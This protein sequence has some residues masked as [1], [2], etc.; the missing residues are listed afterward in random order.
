MLNIVSKMVNEFINRRLLFIFIILSGI[1]LLMLTNFCVSN[2]DSNI[3][4]QEIDDSNAPQPK[5]KP[6]I[7]WFHNVPMTKAVILEKA[8]SNGIISHVLLLYQHRLDAPFT[9]VMLDRTMQ[10]AAVCKKYGTKIIWVRT[11]WPTHNVESFRY[12]DFFDPNYYASAIKEVQLE[13]RAIGA[14]FTGIDIEPYG[15]FPF[16]KQLLQGGVGSGKEFKSL[17]SAVKEAVSMSGQVDFVMPTYTAS[18]RHLYNVVVE[19]GKWKIAEHTY[20]DNPKKINDRRRPFNIFG[21]Y[22]STT[23]RNRRNPKTPFFTAR[24]ILER[25]D[26]WRDKRGLMLYPKEDE[27][28]AVA[29]Q[30][31][32]IKTIVPEK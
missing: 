5:D 30:L 7:I 24:E 17:V 23:K 13:A 19:L 14:E 21:A 22:I 9:G 8:I 1:V 31:S 26:F 2:T 3:P 4:V 25:Q 18:P 12:S 6:I 32:Q 20:Y 29:N 28:K 16:K 10:A 11:L 15:H 27:I